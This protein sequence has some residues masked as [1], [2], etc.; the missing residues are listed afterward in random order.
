MF[1]FQEGPRPVQP[2]YQQYPPSNYQYQN[3]AEEESD[4]AGEVRIYEE[5]LVAEGRPLGVKTQLDDSGIVR[6]TESMHQSNV[7]NRNTKWG[8]KNMR[9]G[10]SS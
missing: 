6:S 1:I 4:R 7:R 9:W 10:W 5:D 8:W 3:Y 2:I